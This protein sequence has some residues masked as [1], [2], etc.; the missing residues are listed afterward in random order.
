[1]DAVSEKKLRQDILDKVRRYY[2]LEHAQLPEFQPGISKVN[3]AGRVFDAEEMC[4]LSEAM[5]D[6]WLSA[7]PYTQ[8]F[9][10]QLADFMGLEHALL[11]NSGSSANLLAFMTLTSPLLGE[12]R[13]KRGDEVI[14]VAAAFPTTVAPILQ[15][16]AL[17]VFIDVE[18]DSANVDVHL[19]KQAVSP[20]S[21]AVMLAH[22]LGNPFNV[23]AVKQFCDKH[24]LWLIEDNCDA[25]GAKYAGQLTGTW[26]DL[27][28]SSFYPS[29][30]I[31]MG[32]GGALYTSNPMLKKIALSL[33]DWGR[34]C[35]CASGQDNAC[36][37]RFKGQFGS[38]P[39]GYDHKYVYS[40]FGYNLHATDMQA[41][42]G[43]AQLKK[44]P[45]FIAK[46]QENYRL[47]SDLLRDLPGL[48]ICTAGTES[49]PSWFGFLMMVQ[50]EAPFK[51]N[52]L[53]RHL[54]KNRIQ[55]RN[56]F[57]GNLIR[58]PC[59]ETLQENKHYRVASSLTNTDFLMNNALWTGL[60]PGMSE[61][62]LLFMATK[63]KE[64]Y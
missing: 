11:V 8:R 63:V 14:T 18:T 7:G 2:E 19:L 64:L 34:D 5:L 54:E 57:A 39:F 35:C 36:G 32:E 9:E 21:K 47:L 55:T 26:G 46:R 44:L 12:R 15:Y 53:A 61:A 37:R 24:G 31:T 56:L 20:K 58:Q 6:F 42:I 33:R 27:G 40:H 41:A 22:T 38:L 4:M 30:H 62:E 10:Q 59:F 3:Y 60:Y 29:H 52:E 13:I 17:P 48:Q 45:A 49:E 1:M 25:L 43:C 50:E 23:R 51:R 28:T 16:G